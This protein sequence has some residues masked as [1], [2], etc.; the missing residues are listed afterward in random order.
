M[1]LMPDAPSSPKDPAKPSSPSKSS[2]GAHAYG[3]MQLAVGVLLGFYGGRW[4]DR[5]LGW[6]PWLTLAGAALGVLAGLY[7][8]FSPL[9]RR[10]PRGDS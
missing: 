6:S 8:F 1:S 7:V 3:G 4:L 10:G 9:F 2:L 5:L